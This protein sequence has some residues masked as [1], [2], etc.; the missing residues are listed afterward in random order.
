MSRISFADLVATR[1]PLTSAE[2]VGLT[3][4]AADALAEC[5]GGA[6]PAD[7][8]LLLSSTGHVSLTNVSIATEPYDTVQTTAALASLARRLLRL[9]DPDAGDRRQRV[10]GGLLVVL[11]RSLR[12]IDLEPLPPGEFR[13]A[14]DRFGSP[15]A[16]VLAAVFWRAARMRMPA[17]RAAAITPLELDAPGR[18][19][20]AARDRRHN[21]PNASELR[22]YLREMERDLYEARSAARV[23]APAAPAPPRVARLKRTTLAAAA[24]VGG[25]VA[26]TLMAFALVAALERRPHLPPASD[27]PVV[28]DA[29]PAAEPPPA[30]LAAART[31]APLLLPAAGGTDVFSPSYAPAGRTL[32]FHAGRQSAPLMRASISDAGEV[33]GVE[34]LLDDGAANYHV[35]MS[36]DGARIA[37]DSDRDGE[38]G[39][40]VANVD[41]TRPTRISGER[42][43]AVP[44]WSPDGGRLAFIRAEPGRP[45]VWNVWIA[46]VR[47]GHLRR[48]TSHA[49]GQPWG[50]SWFP[51]G[52]RIAYSVEDR[53]M[54][55]DLD[56]RLARGYRSPRE[57]R[58]V[59]TP[60]VSPDGTR[61]VF[62][63][64]RDGVWL[65]D[66]ERAR[67]RR[68]LDDATAEEFVWSPAGDS[69]A[70]HA[71]RGGSYG[72]WRLSLAAG[73][74]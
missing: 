34:T 33:D 38:R 72:L 36:P 23:P 57:K 63:V 2:A 31:V 59:R 68:V 18:P 42:Y 71:R 14:L 11:A 64:Q 49:V 46:D 51:D 44:S 52:R 50:A 65:L 22:R 67:M 9:D 48:V 55:A 35:T 8:A 16:A 27:A 56:T 37:F 13:E 40:Y 1:V 66:L 6:L 73:G 3:L 21:V 61:I 5:G 58:L 26:G 7:D 15:D 17:A 70:F 62:Q 69:I 53:L 25:A 30:P 19:D 54:V 39:V 45:K 28:A 29:V 10:P 24:T 43:A 32:L 12:Q 41:G 60:A 4:A 20:A 47:T 74:N